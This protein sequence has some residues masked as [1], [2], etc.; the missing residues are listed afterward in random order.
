[1]R[2]EETPFSKEMQRLSSIA[3]TGDGRVYGYTYDKQGYQTV[4]FE[5]SGFVPRILHALPTMYGDYFS[6]NHGET[7]GYA[8]RTSTQEVVYWVESW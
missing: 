5:E 1:M 7:Y 2:F 4:K 6:W 8:I 3:E